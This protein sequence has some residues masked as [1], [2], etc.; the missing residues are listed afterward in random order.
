M[1]WSASALFLFAL[2][3]PLVSSD[4]PEPGAEAKPRQVTFLGWP[5]EIPRSRSASRD[6]PAFNFMAYP[7]VVQTASGEFAL[8]TIPTKDVTVRAGFYGLI[9]L[10]RGLETKGFQL[11]LP[12]GEG[13]Y[14]W[15]GAYGYYVAASFD[16]WAHKLC[17]RCGLEASLMGRHE[18]EHATG[19]NSGGSATNYSGR[20]IIGDLFLLDAA[21]R[22]ASKDWVLVG[23][24]QNEFF[25][26]GRSSYSQ[27]PG[28][29]LY[30]RYKA[31]KSVHLFASGFAENLFG[32]EAKG[33][34]FPDAYLVRGRLGVAIP[35]RLG[36][37]EV[38]LSG[39]VGHRKGL[40]TFTE[41]RTLGLGIRL[42]L[43]PVSND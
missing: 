21:A 9:E 25:I 35:S 10:E 30:A 31:W 34:A 6:A 2:L 27:G 5:R 26:P 39:D 41:E 11:P 13:P 20:P 8:V 43:G 36:D 1:S 33:R 14:F 42:A 17:E 23:R 22:W 32:T 38:Y 37:I 28:I 7:R 40:L 15:R 18:S 16:T 29:D 24:V 12:R 3:A 4:P 19:S